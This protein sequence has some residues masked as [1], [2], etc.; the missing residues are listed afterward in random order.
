MGRNGNAHGI[1]RAQD[2]GWRVSMGGDWWRGEK[3]K[4]ER[5]DE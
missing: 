4:G 2:A 5:S 1:G 3:G